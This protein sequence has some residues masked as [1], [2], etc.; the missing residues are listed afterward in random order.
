MVTFLYAHRIT[1]GEDSFGGASGQLVITTNEN[2]ELEG[3]GL[4][5]I[6][7]VIFQQIN[8]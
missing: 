6:H 4:Q 5:Q 3:D 1:F 2:T 7:S 8:P